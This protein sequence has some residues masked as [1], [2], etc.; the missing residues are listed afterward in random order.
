MVRPRL[1]TLE[2]RRTVPMGFPKVREGHYATGAHRAWAAAVVER[3]GQA[4]QKCGRTGCRLYADHVVELK[5]GGAPLDTANGQALCGSCH[6][7]K[8]AEARS[9]R[10]HGSPKGSTHPPWLRPSNIPLAI[11]C[12]P[13]G[14]GKTT[15]AKAR[16]GP[17]GIVIDLDELIAKVSGEP[18][19]TSGREWLDAGLRRRNTLLGML[20]RPRPPWARAA[21]VIGEPT[22]QKRQWWVDRLKPD[23]VVV[24]ETPADICAA[25]ICGDPRRSHRQGDLLDAVES[26][27]HRYQRR[28]GE[29]VIANGVSHGAIGQQGSGQGMAHVGAG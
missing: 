1:A 13:P 5:D 19:Y 9:A 21:L 20:S 6:T 23:V 12:G 8:T 25:R 18:I 11:V 26:W 16:V 3:A 14:A 7:T 28:P 27:W 24:L 4:C 17:K 2:V 29:Y 10:R 15:W 22:A